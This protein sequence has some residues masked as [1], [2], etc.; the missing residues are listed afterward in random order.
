MICS[1]TST[2][3]I[4]DAPL[5]AGCGAGFARLCVVCSHGAS[6][7]VACGAQTAELEQNLLELVDNQAVPV[8]GRGKGYASK[9]IAQKGQL[10]VRR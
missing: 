8:L 7:S 10:G 6:G 5:H 3:H 2:T 9:G 4:L 1:H